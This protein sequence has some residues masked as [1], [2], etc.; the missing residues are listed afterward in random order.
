MGEFDALV[1]VSEWP[2]VVAH[3]PETLSAE[4]IDYFIETMK[5][6]CYQRGQFA[7]VV[8]L[9]LLIPKSATSTLRADLFKRSNEV[10]AQYPSSL[11]GEAIA[12]PTSLLRGLVQAYLWFKDSDAYETKAVE[13]MDVGMAWARDLVTQKGIS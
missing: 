13:S 11:V 7:I 9:S 4:F 8:D 12:V 2:V 6:E 5:T 3:F 10:K 1:D